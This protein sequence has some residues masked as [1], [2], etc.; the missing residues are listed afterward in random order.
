[1]VDWRL[2]K[3]MIPP[4]NQKEWEDEFNKYKEYP[5]WKYYNKDKEM[6]LSQFKF[7]F[8]MEWGHRMWGRT[9]G[10]IFLLPAAYFWSK[11]YF[12]SAMKKRV[13]IFSA[14]LGFQGFL[15]NYKM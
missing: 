12:T 6:T 15:G 9:T 7:I 10:L 13:I 3:D 14:L 8:Y 1:M 5:E 2:V 4:K 11:S